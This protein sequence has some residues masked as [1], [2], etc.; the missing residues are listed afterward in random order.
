MP[1]R[2]CRRESGK[3]EVR[4]QPICSQAYLPKAYQFRTVLDHNTLMTI[5][6]DWVVLPE[7]N[8]FPALSGLVDHGDE[9]INLHEA[10][11]A[12]TLNGA[13]A[14][15]K[16]KTYGS[17]EVGKSADMIVLDR[18]LFEIPSAQIADTLVLETVFEGQVVYQAEQY[19]Q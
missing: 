17:I 14:V 8:L 9:S 19:E 3:L 16:Q 10:I 15:G 6:S 2:K 12:M 4:S 18:N 13:I 5:G 7:P 1:S 11:K